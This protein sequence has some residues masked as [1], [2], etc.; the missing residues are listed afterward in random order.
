VAVTSESEASCATAR[1]ACL[2]SPGDALAQTTLRAAPAPID[3][4]VF[5]SAL[6]VGCDFPVSLLEDCANSLAQSV[7]PAAEA[8]HCS[9]ASAILDIDAAQQLASSGKSTDF[10]TVCL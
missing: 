10:V 8:V 4:E 5:D 9:E 1:D 7:V 6:T 3:C 2:E